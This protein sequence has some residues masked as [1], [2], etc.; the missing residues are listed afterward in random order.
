MN[1]PFNREFYII[2]NVAAGGTNT[3]FPDGE[4]GKTW[5]NDD[6]RA[7]NTF[8]N[9]K[10]EWYSTWNYPETNQSAMKVDSV[11]VWSLDEEVE[12]TQ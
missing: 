11:K 8:W 1:A 4:C 9:S 7:P 2:L 10:D 5:T 3:Y 6:P 12:F